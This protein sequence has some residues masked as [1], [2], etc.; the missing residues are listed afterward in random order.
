VFREEWRLS[1]RSSGAPAV[2]VNLL[3]QWV[4]LRA[5]RRRE[6]IAEVA[7][8][9]LTERGHASQLYE[10]TG[11]RFFTFDQA[12]GEIGRATRRSIPDSAISPPAYRDLLGKSGVPTEVIEMLLY[13]LGTVLDRRYSIVADGVQQALGCAPRD[14]QDFVR[15]TASAGTW[16]LANG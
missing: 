16:E 12:A 1:P 11:P 13:L 15:R 4:R 10:L 8:V 7:V 5:V 9:A 2:L 3:C 14:F 6:N